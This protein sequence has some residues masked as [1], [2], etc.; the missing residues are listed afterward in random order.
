MKA[1]S[2]TRPYIGILGQL[3]L[4]LTLPEID[5]QQKIAS[6]LSKFDEKIALLTAKKNKLTEYKKGVMQR[7]FNGKW[8]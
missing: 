7:L 2:G 4:N 8:G 6:F 5:E 3:T 1:D